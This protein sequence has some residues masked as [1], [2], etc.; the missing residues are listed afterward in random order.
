MCGWSATVSQTPVLFDWWNWWNDCLL[1]YAMPSVWVDTEGGIFFKSWKA[2][3][4]N[5][6]SKDFLFIQTNALDW[7][8]KNDMASPSHKHMLNQGSCFFQYIYHSH[9]LYVCFHHLNTVCC[10]WSSGFQTFLVI[11][12][13]MLSIYISNFIELT[14][15]N[16]L[17]FNESK[18]MTSNNT[19]L[20]KVQ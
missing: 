11:P 10:I 19:K 7:K 14:S 8:I 16:V 13:K 3:T 20:K 1:Y 12:L 6:H 9:I 17:F 4:D 15:N 18:S 2:N 5:G